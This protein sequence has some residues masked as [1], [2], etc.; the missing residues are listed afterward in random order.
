MRPTH[1]HAHMDT[2]TISRAREERPREGDDHKER[3]Q[4]TR[5]PSMAHRRRPRHHQKRGNPPSIINP[6]QTRHDKK[7]ATRSQALPNESRRD[8]EGIRPPPRYRQRKATAEQRRVGSRKPTELWRCGP[9]TGPLAST[10]VWPPEV[11]AD[12]ALRPRDL[13]ARGG[14]ELLLAVAA[15]PSDRP[16]L[17]ATRVQGR[18][19]SRKAQGKD[20]RGES[21]STAASAGSGELGSKSAG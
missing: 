9:A 5:T 13:V 7:T 4:G 12:G 18:G 17:Q 10:E 15:A 21:P 6:H 14:R 16:Q 20:S 11:E 8:P 1:M 2:T 19:G 3:P